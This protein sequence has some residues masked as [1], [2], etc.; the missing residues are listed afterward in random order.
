M[1]VCSNCF[2]WLSFAWQFTSLTTGAWPFLSTN[3]S[4]GNVAMLLRSGEIFYY[5]VTTN[6]LLSL[7]V[8]EFRKSV[9]IWQS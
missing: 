7:S 2:E 4:Q 6:L 1:N 3:I 5:R 9:S 8:K